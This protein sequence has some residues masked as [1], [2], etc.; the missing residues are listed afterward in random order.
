M[1][2][3]LAKSVADCNT[4]EA[5]G[6]GAAVCAAADTESVRRLLGLPWGSIWAMASDLG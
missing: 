1:I 6:L 4:T 2:P 3:Y 5:N